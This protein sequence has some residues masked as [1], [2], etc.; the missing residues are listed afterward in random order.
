MK[1][2]LNNKITGRLL[3]SLVLGCIVLVSCDDTDPAVSFEKPFPKRKKNLWWKLGGQFSMQKYGDTLTLNHVFDSDDRMNYLIFEDA[4]DTVFAG[5]VSKYRGLYFFDH[6]INDT[7][8]WISAVDINK[9]IFSINTI[10]G[11]GTAETQMELLEDAIRRGKYQELITYTSKDSSSIYLNPD[12]EILYEFYAS[13]LDTMPADTLVYLP[14]EKQSE[15]ADS[16]VVAGV[17][18]STAEFDEYQ[19]YEE[20]SM[21]KNLYPNPAQE[22]CFLEIYDAGNYIYELIDASGVLYQTNRITEKKIK[23]DLSGLKPG[24]YF[25]RFYPVDKERVETMKLV[26]SE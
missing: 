17:E 24:I 20:N 23:I 16:T 22:Y 18:E 10:T 4:G 9:N 13:V 26:V 14:D 11:L 3:I 21:I 8:Y 2:S 25:I 5:T 12:K 19:D 1:K 15:P 6:Q 7:S